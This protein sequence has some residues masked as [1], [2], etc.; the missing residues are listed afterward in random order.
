MN[1]DTILILACLL[2]TLLGLIAGAVCWRIAPR[3]LGLIYGGV[4]DAR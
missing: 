2:G 3:F 1:P 4:S